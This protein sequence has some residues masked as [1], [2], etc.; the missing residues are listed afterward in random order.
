MIVGDLSQQK[1]KNMKK[2]FLIFSIMAITV[3][4]LFSQNY[5]APG[6]LNMPLLS[7]EG[8]FKVMAFNGST[9]GVQAS[10]ALKD[11]LVLFGDYSSAQGSS[12][13]LPNGAY[14][15]STLVNKLVDIG[16]GCYKN[17]T[18]DVR[19]EILGGIGYGI[20][21]SESYQEAGDTKYD[22]AME[23]VYH[24]GYF[25]GGNYNW[26][27]VYNDGPAQRIYS[28]LNGSYLK[29]FA[30]PSVGLSALNNHLEL[31]IGLRLNQVFFNDLTYIVTTKDGPTGKIES[32]QHN[33][34]P[35]G[36]PIVEPGLR[37]AFGFKK[38]KLNASLTWSFRGGQ[39]VQGT[40]AIGILVDLFTLKHS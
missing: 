31:G 35:N 32:V 16:V 7:K 30:Q 14:Y 26:E 33:N 25:T 18:P 10:I 24:G 20:A 29:M 15:T 2:I 34:I 3:T 36:G 1:T 17:I 19:F 8:E 5:Y 13:E 23:Y 37:M 40:S 21:N 11:N 39:D 38:V 12:F 6:L 22:S 27:W 28:S 9:S 4:K